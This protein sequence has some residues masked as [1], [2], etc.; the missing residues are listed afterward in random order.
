MKTVKTKIYSFNE[1]TEEAQ[2]NAIN[3]YRNDFLNHDFIYDD[4]YKTVEKFNELF[5]LKEGQSSWLNFST[6]FENNIEDLKGLRLQKYILN[7]YGNDLFKRKYLKHGELTKQEPKKWHKMRKYKVI[8]QGPNKGLFLI[9][10]YSNLFVV[11]L[12]NIK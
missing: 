12:F 11:Y 8:N 7:N 2:Q 10:Y 6:N 3:Q 4:A 9:S 1:L 5:G